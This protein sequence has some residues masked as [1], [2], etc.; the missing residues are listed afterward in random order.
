MPPADRFSICGLYFWW[1]RRDSLHVTP[2][3]S[4][5]IRHNIEIFR[6][7]LSN[8]MF[9]KSVWCSAKLFNVMLYHLFVRWTI[10]HYTEPFHA[11]LH[12]LCTVSQ[13]SARLFVIE[14]VHFT[15]S[16]SHSTQATRPFII[17]RNFSCLGCSSRK[18]K[19]STIWPWHSFISYAILQLILRRGW[20]RGGGGG[21]QSHI[22]QNFSIK[23]RIT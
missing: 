16:C 13:T 21:F 3:A 1:F 10:R 18:H 12:R 7:M 2:Q 9:S 20:Q 17:W 15:I 6:V 5:T 22:T 14:L 11:T 19:P 8:L 4:S 23:S